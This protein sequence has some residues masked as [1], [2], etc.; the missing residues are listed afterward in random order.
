ME[1]LRGEKRD[2]RERC[3]ERRCCAENLVGGGDGEECNLT[4]GPGE[5]RAKREDL[6]VEGKRICRNK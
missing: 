4:E 2:W 1:F 5:L 6:E 3:V